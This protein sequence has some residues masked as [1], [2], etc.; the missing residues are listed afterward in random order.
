MGWMNSDADDIEASIGAVTRRPDADPTKMIAIG[1]SAGG[2]AS[3]A[4]GAR[5]VPGL[6]AV[7]NIAGGEHLAGCAAVNDSI[8]LDFRRSLGRAAI[9]PI[10]GCSRK[11]ISI[12]RS[13][14]SR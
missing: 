2:A 8:P 13:I 12:I 9:F 3:L 11:T 4:L 14:R 1:E 6:A 5:N 10:S 7:I